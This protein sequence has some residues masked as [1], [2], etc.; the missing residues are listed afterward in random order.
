MELSKEKVRII[1]L[2]EYEI[3]DEVVLKTDDE[4]LTR[5]VSGYSVGPD[6]IAYKLSC[7]ILE[8]PHYG[9]EIIDK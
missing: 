3:G 4:K 1:L 5:I 2:V 7:G 8:T 6:T 9:F